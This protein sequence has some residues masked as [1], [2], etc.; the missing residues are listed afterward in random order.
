MSWVSTAFVGLV[1]ITF[2]LAAIALLG[3]TLVVLGEAVTLAY[4]ALKAR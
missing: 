1:V 3:V 4:R 2:G